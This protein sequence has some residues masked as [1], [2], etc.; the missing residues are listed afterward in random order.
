MTFSAVELFLTMF[1]HLE[2][3]R[4]PNEIEVL[5]QQ[6]VSFQLLEDTDIPA[7]VWEE[8]IVKVDDDIRY[9]RI[10][11]L[12]NHIFNMNVIGSTELKFSKLL[13]VVKTVC[14]SKF[15]YFRRMCL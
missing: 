13:E 7:S 10:D 8:A 3:L 11:V 15:K 6:F 4:Q 2:A 1:P 12:W 5:Q 9:T 14:D